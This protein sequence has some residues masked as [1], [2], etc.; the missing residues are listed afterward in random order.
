M[1]QKMKTGAIISIVQQVTSQDIRLSH[2]DLP[3]ADAAVAI[4]IATSP[5][6]F[7]KSFHVLGT[8]VA[9]VSRGGQNRLE[10]VL[11]EAL[12]QS[13]I[14]KEIGWAI[15]QRCSRT[16][17]LAARDV[18]PGA[19][20]LVRDLYPDL[21]F[22]GADTLISL[23]S[24]FVMASRPPAGKGVIWL[25]GESGFVGVL[26]IDAQSVSLWNRYIS[27][28]AQFSAASL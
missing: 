5:I 4:G 25:A 17:L 20:W 8:A 28:E 16:F 22:G 1:E 26:V 12:E 13:G 11:D 14:N 23:H 9:Q 2:N 15:G 27:E 24:L 7:G 19:R 18:L 10:T 3:F 6:A 21:N